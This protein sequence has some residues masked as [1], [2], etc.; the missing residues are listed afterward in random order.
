MSILP[1][2]EAAAGLLP[3]DAAIGELI[4]L[5]SALGRQQILDFYRSLRLEPEAL[6][7]HRRF[8]PASYCRNRIFANDCFELLLLCWLP[9]QQSRIHNHHGSRCGVLVVEGIASETVFTAAPDGA[10]LPG[11]TR[12]LAAG[13]L[14]VNEHQ[15]IH[16][17]SNAHER[18]LVTLHLYSPPL[19]KMETFSAAGPARERREPDR[20]I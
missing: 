7:R 16:R 9:G 12:R 19:L 4:A 5:Q 8:D 14:A 18:N 2:P 3:L 20:Q 15:D 13:S 11:I 10:A 17:I 1:P 6:A